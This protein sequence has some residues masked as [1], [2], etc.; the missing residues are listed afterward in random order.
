MID[1]VTHAASTTKSSINEATE[2]ILTSLLQHFE[3]SFYAA[4]VKN[5]VAD[6]LRTKM[7]ALSVEALLTESQVQ[8]SKARVMF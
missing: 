7:D 1:F 2:R 8:L 5:G 4:A 6:S 3:D